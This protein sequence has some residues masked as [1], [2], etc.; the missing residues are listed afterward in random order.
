[1]TGPRLPWLVATAARLIP[2]D[3]RH[4]VVAD[5]IEEGERLGRG[6]LWLA[7]QLVRSA[8]DHR[9]VLQSAQRQDSSSVEA[10][11]MRS[12]LLLPTLTDLRLAARTVRRGGAST[13][14]IVLTLALAIGGT[15]AMYGVVHAV[16]LEA[17]PYPEPDRLVRIWERH[18]P[19]NRTRNVVAP[20]NFMEWRDRA[21]TLTEF[22]AIS[23]GF[24]IAVT[25]DGA[26][27]EVP[28]ANVTWNLFRQL[29]ATAV[30]G[31]TFVES[32]GVANTEP[33]AMLGW[34][35]WQRR[36]GGDPQLVD[37]SIAL[38]G[39]P[40]RVVGIL[41]ADFTLLGHHV[42]VFRL[43]VPDEVWRA[44]RGRSLEVLARLAPGA[45]LAEA[46]AEMDT[47]AT[48]LEAQWPQFDAGWRV[49]VIDARADLV[50]HADRPLALL[51]AAVALVLL[52]GCANA[53]NLVLARAAERRREFEVRVALGATRRTLVGQLVLEGLVLATAGTGA[54]LL[55]A[56]AALWLVTGPASH[57]FGIPRLENAT[58]SL[59]VIAAALGL[60]T[61][62]TLAF[63]LVPGWR[64]LRRSG[65][66]APGSGTRVWTGGRAE[67]RLRTGLVVVQIA[68]AVVLVIGAGLVGRSLVRLVSVEPGFDAGQVL[69][70]TVSPPSA[71]YDEAARLAL[72]ERVAGT[73]R[74][75]PGVE[76]V[77]AI[78]WLP[79]AGPGGGTSFDVD[80]RV[81]LAAANRPVADIRPVDA[82]YFGVMRIPIRQGRVFTADEVRTGARVAVV[83]ESLVRL[84]F[85]NENPLGKRLQVNWNPGLDEIVGVV[86]DVK[87]VGLSSEP[88]SQIYFPIGSAN[89]GF[90]TFVV[91]TTI[92]E[93]ALTRAAGAAV[94]A[95]DPNLP[96]R[97]VLPMRAR[98]DASVAAPEAAAWLVSA[99]GALA[100]L[101]A[102]VGVAGLQAALV[103]AR[104]P[105]LAI[106]L[107]LGATPAGIR[108]LVMSGA[109]RLIATGLAL[110]LAGALLASRG[111]AS[112]LY[113]TPA[114]DPVAYLT[115]M[116]AV[117][118]LGLLACAA[119]VRRAAN[120]PPAA[121]LRS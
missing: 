25:G 114:A 21:T 85:P 28:G 86:G 93:T 31:R 52:V 65:G 39:R 29:G 71:R 51:L 116:V 105:E 83:N 5:V 91:R 19:R 59:P 79:F 22:T 53:A 73:L 108:W 103:A 112:L 30:A 68:F 33:L 88:R 70:F 47:I 101:L 69:T 74:A 76:R 110:G 78:T 84:M 120:T 97:D 75:Q 37:R 62:C 13:A 87:L 56:S 32:D 24:Y 54:A 81:P 72:Y 40:T 80:G 6:S 67:R 36:Y 98:I 107:A 44:P 35:L 8:R 45:T 95:V 64:A 57:A 12:R 11:S 14:A 55:V 38:A 104:R 61:F 115:A 106:R 63:G 43:H 90:V 92:D 20:A 9:R 66:L 50:G 118:T 23:R 46:N 42:D 58:I 60:L 113:D 109:G 77:G 27:E 34:N 4:D 94:H 7:W 102:L 49:D 48:T 100:L 121:V 15:T 26:P 119:A 10:T 18:V 111:L 3:H 2:R 89:V 117:A 1:M 16:L 17:L 41:P 99:F 96:L 82:D